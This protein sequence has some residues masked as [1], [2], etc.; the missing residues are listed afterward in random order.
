M[1]INALPPELP[2]PRLTLRRLQS[3]DAETVF[4]VAEPDRDWLQPWLPWADEPK[5]E[6]TRAYLESSER[7]FEAGTQAHYGIWEAGEYLGNVGVQGVVEHRGEI[8]YWL[9]KRATGAGRMTEAVAALQSALFEVG[10]RRIEIL[11]A[12][13]NLPSN[14]VPKRLGYTLDGVLRDRIELYGAFHDANLWSRLSTD[15]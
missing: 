14:A 11:C 13:G 15:P 7:N 2:G 6:T 12:V 4:A 8:G 10:L 9:A 5:L 1:L 3:S